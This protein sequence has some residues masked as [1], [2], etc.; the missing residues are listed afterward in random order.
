MLRYQ[1][2]ALRDMEDGG[3]RMPKTA[4]SRTSWKADWKSLKL[5]DRVFNIT[6]FFITLVAVVISISQLTVVAQSVVI[7]ISQP[8]MVAQ[9]Q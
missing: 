8:T 6:A 1:T 2:G 7:S 9:S 3:L 5:W 4:M